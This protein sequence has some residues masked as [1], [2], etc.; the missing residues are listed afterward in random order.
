MSTLRFQMV[1]EAIRRKALDVKAPANHV[2][3]YN[4]I[5]VFRGVRSSGRDNA[6]R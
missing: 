1:G 4:G 2:Y 6:G 3:E 5:N